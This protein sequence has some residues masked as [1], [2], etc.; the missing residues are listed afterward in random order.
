MFNPRWNPRRA[1]RE[2]R[3]AILASVVAVAAAL[4]G[5]PPAHATQVSLVGTQLRVID[6][7][8]DV[9]AIEVLPTPSGYDVFDNVDLTLGMGC[10]TVEPGHAAC[11]AVVSDIYVDAGA[12]DDFVLLSEV[13]SPVAATGGTGDDFVEGGPSD[14]RLGGATGNDNVVGGASEDLINGGTGSDLLDGGDGDDGLAGQTGE[15]SLLGDAGSDK[16]FGDAGGDLVV[17][18]SGPDDLRAGAGEDVLVTGSG[19]DNAVT[20]DDDDLVFAGPG[21]TIDCDA[22]DRVRSEDGPPP[23]CG[24]LPQQTLVPDS[25]WPRPPAGVSAGGDVSANEGRGALARAA[26]APPDPVGTI[27]G[28]VIHPG[29]ARRIGVKFPYRYRMTIRVRVRPYDRDGNRLK[30]FV[31]NVQTRVPDKIDSPDPATWT[32]RVDCCVSA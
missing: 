6:D 24:R 10:V 1:A 5:A 30:A 3:P 4:V 32:A 27:N 2:P 29:K 21:D 18:G 22:G 14:D 11:R 9:N 26:V 19:I 16:M 31:R 20:G 15:D 13:T 12:G 25:V 8:G 7:R 28:I 17:G 23:G